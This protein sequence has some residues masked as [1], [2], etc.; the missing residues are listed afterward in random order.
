[1]SKNTN[2]RMSNLTFEHFMAE[3]HFWESKFVQ[4]KKRIHNTNPNLQYRHRKRRRLFYHVKNK[5]PELYR[6]PVR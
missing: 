1:M 4:S 2:V 6:C 5:Y 3:N